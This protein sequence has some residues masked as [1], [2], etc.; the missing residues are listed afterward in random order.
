MV[1]FGII[2]IL[3]WVL[4]I[5][6]FISLLR[7]NFTK[8]KLSSDK[9]SS[10]SKLRQ[11][12]LVALMLSLLFGLGWGV[13]LVATTSIPVL[14]I[15]L[16]LQIIFILLT[17]FQGLLLFIMNCVRS[18]EARNEWKRWVDA[19]TCHRVTFKD[20]K[21]LRLT[22]TSGEYTSRSKGTGTMSTATTS[23]TDTI[24]RAVKKDMVSSTL[25]SEK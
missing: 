12:F 14:A 4:F 22:S 9:S 1:P 24:L 20:R 19:V 5:I 3:N 21:K 23:G 15:S 16:T 2:Y 13:G 7:K 8:N 10:M 6:I 11:Q 25:A 17:S 18:A